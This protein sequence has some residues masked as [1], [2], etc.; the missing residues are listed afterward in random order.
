MQSLRTTTIKNPTPAQVESLREAAYLS[1]VM[2]SIDA[3]IDGM[4]KTVHVA[5][6]EHIRKGTLTPEA[7]MNYWMELYSYHRLRHRLTDKAATAN[8]II[9]KTGE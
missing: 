9:E 8:T 3:E 4:E 6:Y 5:V 2:P 7:A 1:T